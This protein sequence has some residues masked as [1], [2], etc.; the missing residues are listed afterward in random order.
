[1]N[2]RDRLI[3]DG[4]PPMTVQKFMFYHVANPQIWRSFEN[5]ALALW[6]NGIKHFGAKAIFETIRYEE[7]LAKGADGFKANNNW[8]AYYARIFQYKHNIENFFETREIKGVESDG[9]I[10]A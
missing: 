6:N 9:S 2:Y 5:K 1:M 4:V 8:A 10:N 3:S 7:T